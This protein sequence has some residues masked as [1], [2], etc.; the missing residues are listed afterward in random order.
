MTGVLSW[1]VAAMAGAATVGAV[2][3]G[4]GSARRVLARWRVRYTLEAQASLSEVFLFVAPEMMWHINGLVC[5]TAAVVAWLLIDSAA[6]SLTAALMVAPLPRAA[7]LVL[8][9]RRVTRIDIQ[10][11]DAARSVAAVLRA[12]A[13]LPAALRWAADHTPTPLAQELGLI[14][15]E[16]R[17]GVPFAEALAHLELRLGTEAVGLLTATLRVGA[18]TGGDLS[19]LLEQ[20]A[21]MQ[22]R[23]LQVATRVRTLTSQA[24]VQ[25]LVVGAL[26]IMLLGVLSVLA[27][28]MMA[29][30]WHTPEGWAALGLIFLL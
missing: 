2:A 9:R 18:T 15:R 13:S 22:R 27:P 28:D 4:Y 14:L 23:R 3:L 1:L 21:R 25:A 10:L 6:A 7:L 8:R 30:F 11:P 26:P 20:F 17:V 19:H 24:G 16:H 12:G 29:V 5:A